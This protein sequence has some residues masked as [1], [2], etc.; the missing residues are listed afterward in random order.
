MCKGYFSTDAYI[1]PLFFGKCNNF[2]NIILNFFVYKIQKKYPSERGVKN[3][4]YDVYYDV[5][6]EFGG[7]RWSRTTNSS[8]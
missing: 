2:L 5:Y 7:E 4:V 8:V 6:Y 3:F 1:I